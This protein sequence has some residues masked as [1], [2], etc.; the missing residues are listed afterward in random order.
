MLSSS[1]IQWGLEPEPVQVENQFHIPPSSIADNAGCRVASKP[2]RPN[3][4][5]NHLALVFFLIAETCFE[6]VVGLSSP[7]LSFV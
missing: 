5:T 7:D 3:T 2:N 1:T 4:T 6:C